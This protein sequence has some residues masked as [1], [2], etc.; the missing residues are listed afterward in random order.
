ML[1]MYL[2]KI[3]KKGKKEQIM[4]WRKAKQIH[5]WFVE[6]V[7]NGNDNGGEYTVTKIDL[8]QLLSFCEIVVESCK[9]FENTDTEMIEIDVLM[10]NTRLKQY[11]PIFF[12][13]NK[14]DFESIIYTQDE[15]KKILSNKEKCTYVY[16]VNQ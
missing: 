14:C 12:F 16:K 4:Y 10:K 15:L 7:Q 9:L 6:N 13:D 2:Y 8:K 5:N 11:K 3:N 1:E